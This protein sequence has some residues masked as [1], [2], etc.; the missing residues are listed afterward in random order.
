VDGVE[1]NCFCALHGYDILHCG[2]LSCLHI[3]RI[4]G[5]GY[6]EFAFSM[7]SFGS[8]RF[9]LP[10]LPTARIKRVI[11]SPRRSWSRLLSSVMSDHFEWRCLVDFLG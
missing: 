1:I 7:H 4:S 9:S 5:T 3:G 10:R 8:T 2:L 11:R 6:F